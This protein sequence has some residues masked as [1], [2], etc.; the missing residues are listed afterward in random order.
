MRW[1]PTLIDEASNLKPFPDDQLKRD[2][3]ANKKK[4]RPMRFTNP[5]PRSFVAA[6]LGEPLDADRKVSI[7]DESVPDA[8]VVRKEMLESRW[9]S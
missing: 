4:A 1:E 6:M 9:P 7:R 3:C 8:D 5:L 2:V